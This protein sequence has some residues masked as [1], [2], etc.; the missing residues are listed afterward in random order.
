MLVERSN[1]RFVSKVTR[2]MASA[3]LS[4]AILETRRDVMNAAKLNLSPSGAEQDSF[5]LFG[6]QQHPVLQE[7]QPDRC[8]QSVNRNRIAMIDSNL[9]SC[10]LLQMCIVYRPT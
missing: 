1:L 9:A 3:A 6:I 2:R 10:Q 7:V 8:G 5:R 4:P